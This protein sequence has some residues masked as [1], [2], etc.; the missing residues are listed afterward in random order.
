MAEGN[1]LARDFEQLDRL[2]EL[3]RRAYHRGTALSLDHCLPTYTCATSASSLLP[4]LCHTTLLWHRPYPPFLRVHAD[5][6]LHS[7][8][9]S[10]GEVDHSI[11]LYNPIRLVRDLHLLENGQFLGGGPGSFTMQL[12]RSATPMGPCRRDGGPGRHSWGTHKRQGG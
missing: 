5:P 10:V 11:C 8:A 7:P 3:R 12:D 6:S 9:P 4:R 1:R 2:A